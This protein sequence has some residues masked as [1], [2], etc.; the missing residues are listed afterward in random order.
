MN[1]KVPACCEPHCRWCKVWVANDNLQ[2]YIKSLE[3]GLGSDHLALKCSEKPYIPLLCVCMFCVCAGTC[4]CVDCHR[5]YKS[6]IY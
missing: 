4:V 5:L 6:V 1:E 2:E 3:F